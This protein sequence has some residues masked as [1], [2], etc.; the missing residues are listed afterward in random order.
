MNEKQLENKFYSFL[1]ERGFPKESLLS[2]VPLISSKGRTYQPDLIIVDTE[3][4]EYIA[5]IEFKI[6]F[7]N[8]ISQS[9]ANQVTEY[10]S[11]IGSRTTPA[12]LVIPDED[13]FRVFT[14]KN[15]EEWI[16]IDKNEFPAL[17]TLSSKKIIDE[18][19]YRRELEDQ[20]MYD[21]LLKKKKARQ[22]STWAL[23]STFIG[24]IIT[25]IT[26]YFSQN[27]FMSLKASD[28]RTCCDSL[29]LK[30]SN[31]QLQLNE[32]SK[33]SNNPGVVDT[34]L[35]IDSTKT[36]SGLSARLEIIENGISNNPQQTL[37][38]ISLR[39]E[40]EKLKAELNHKAELEQ[41][42]YISIENR[43]DYLNGWILGIVIA[44]LSA[45]LGVFITYNLKGNNTP[46]KH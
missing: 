35:I 36:Y 26:W 3:I 44:I 5:L 24:M 18:K 12:F 15:L 6:R 40:L 1:F 41:A 14:L 42:K 28:D 20:K 38:I 45:A 10:L 43:L 2:N 46:N 11:L 21:E 4:D 19:L 7:D 33:L 17:D 31:L 37:S 16:E 32:I 27:E 9:S 30:I 23:T 13:D 22:A 39:N 34:L 29:T 8:K 25:V